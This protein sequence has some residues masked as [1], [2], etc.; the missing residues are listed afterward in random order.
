MDSEKSEPKVV[1]LVRLLN[2]IDEGRHSFEELK[3]RIADGKPPSTRSLRRYL[4]V[5]ADAGFP[6]YFDRTTGTYRFSTGYSLKRLNL[7]SREL[8]GLVT[9]KRLGASLGGTLGAYIDEATSKLLTSADRRTSAAID[10]APS[11]TIKFDEVALDPETERVFEVLQS[12][13]RN[14]RR[15]AFS[16]VDKVGNPSARRVD[17]Y[18]FI[19]SNGRVY[20]VGYDHARNAMRVFA[21]DNISDPQSLA[22]TF[23]R[24]TDF[25]L[26]AFGAHSVSGVVHAD[27]LTEVTVRF[28]P[29]VAKAAVL[30]PAARSRRVERAADGSAEVTYAVADPMEIVRWSLSWG[31]EAEVLRPLSARESAKALLGAIS[32]RYA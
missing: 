23:E 29:I 13:E 11:L 4:A 25:N 17:P 19:V 20:L 9:L 7:N 3:H 1:L 12:A 27:Q 22:A 14:R 5:L 15:V 24:P 26:D 30:A 2:A 6:W 21:V 10:G 31:A 18:G 32:S 28:S 16:Y 8:F